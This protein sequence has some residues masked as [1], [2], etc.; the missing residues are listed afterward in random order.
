MSSSGKPSTVVITITG[1]GMANWRTISTSPSS[2]HSSISDVASRSMTGRARS[3][4]APLNHGS[5]RTRYSRCS[6]GSMPRV[7]LRR[8][9]CSS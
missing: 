1:S 5:T 6:G 7:C 2:I 9:P 4:P 8:H 3:A